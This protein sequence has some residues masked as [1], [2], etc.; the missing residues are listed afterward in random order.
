[1]T[2]GVVVVEL[3][4]GAGFVRVL[5]AGVVGAKKRT[6]ALADAVGGVALFADELNDWS[7]RARGVGN[8]NRICPRKSDDSN[9][10]R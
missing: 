4:S 5:V 3:S 8:L 2:L 7:R 10:N 6:P 1:V 9:E